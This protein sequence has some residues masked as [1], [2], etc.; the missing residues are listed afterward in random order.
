MFKWFFKDLDRLGPSFRG[1]GR[2]EDPA[3]GVEPELCAD[4]KHYHQMKI[5]TLN[6]IIRISVMVMLIMRNMIKSGG[7]SWF[8]CQTRLVL[9][10]KKWIIVDHGHGHLHDH[11][12]LRRP[13]QFRL[14]DCDDNWV[15]NHDYH[16]DQDKDLF[17]CSADICASDSVLWCRCSCLF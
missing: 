11:S 6:I 3:S 2:G 8:W 4:L 10:P 12:H 14:N 9:G 7:G 17:S 5:M 1:G 16:V 15:D 13:F